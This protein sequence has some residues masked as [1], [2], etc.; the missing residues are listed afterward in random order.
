MVLDSLHDTVEALLD[1]YIEYVR[2][3]TQ[4]YVGDHDTISRAFQAQ[5]KDIAFSRKSIQCLQTRIQGTNTLLSSLLALRNNVSL[6]QIAQEEHRE[7]A[8]LRR[9]NEKGAN[10]SSA[11]K[12]L[13]VI[14]LIY[15]PILVV[16]VR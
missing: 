2:S 11:V 9:L 5:A 1:N 16:C 15:L 10:D 13:I 4:L 8:L 7:N 6:K 3:S 14:I 12:A